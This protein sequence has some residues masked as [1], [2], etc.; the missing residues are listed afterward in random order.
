MDSDP[1]T[2]QQSGKD[3]RNER[4]LAYFHAEAAADGVETAGIPYQ[5]PSLIAYGADAQDV[6]MLSTYICLATAFLSTKVPAIIKRMG[7]RKKAILTIAFVDAITWLPLVGV[8]WF[9]GPVNPLWLIPLWIINLVPG[10][11]IAPARDSWMADIVPGHKMGRYFGLRSMIMG[12]V[13]LGT[14]YIMGY[15]LDAY[16]GQVGRGFATIFL[17]AAIA[18]FASVLLYGLIHSPRRTEE[19][20]SKFGFV[21]FLKETRSGNLGRFILFIASFNFAVYLSAPLFGVYL[22]T[23]LHLSYLTFSI[24]MSTEYIAKVLS[25]R[26]WGRYADRVGHL[27]VLNVASS[28]IPFVPMLWLLSPNVGY[29]IAVQFFSG[30]AWAG[31]DLCSQNFIYR[32][33]PQSRRL[34]YIVYNKSLSMLFMALGAMVGAYLV[35][36]IFPVF[37]NTLLGLFLISGALRFVVVRLMLGRVRDTEGVQELLQSKPAAN[38]VSLAEVA[39]S[40]ARRGFFYRPQE[41]VRLVNSPAFETPTMRVNIGPSSARKRGFLYRPQDWEQFVKHPSLESPAAGADVKL[42]ASRRQGFFYRRQEWP[43]FVT[44]TASETPNMGVDLELRAYRIPRTQGLF[45]RPNDW[46]RFLKLSSAKASPTGA[47]AR[48]AAPRRWGFFY[49]PND[50][51]GFV[52]RPSSTNREAG[53]KNLKPVAIPA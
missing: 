32:C 33:S 18:S 4:S 45:Y 34:K 8:L 23:D 26:L 36:R 27:R 50:C 51:T 49:R 1:Q 31:F 14:F 17:I 43:R 11:V 35:N 42:A 39:V 7:S 29:L 40:S 52:K 6:A 2:P 10:L 15:I 47:S 19:D 3:T 24:V 5:G 9:I 16:Y 38:T 53:W 22:L 25:V 21:D 30:V 20:D 12:A 46:A 48:K 13:Y 44:G 28:L 37:G 41:W